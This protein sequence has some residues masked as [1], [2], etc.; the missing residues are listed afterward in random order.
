MQE[1]LFWM[2]LLVVFVGLAWSGWREYRKVEAYRLWAQQFDRSKYDIYAALGYG[3]AILTW[4]KPTPQ[5]VVDLKS[6]PLEQVQS[7]LLQ[8][9]QQEV[10]WHQ[11]PTKGKII[12]LELVVQGEESPLSIPF[13]EIPL[14]VE[15]AAYLHQSL[16]Q[17]RSATDP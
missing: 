14:A 13:T 6:Y 2:V 15:W 5:G 7:V 4:G 17:A 1:G 8:V 11:P 12:A 10:D 9:D 3:D 16:Q